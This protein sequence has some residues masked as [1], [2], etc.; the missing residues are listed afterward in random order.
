MPNSTTKADPV[1]ARRPA[2][3]VGEIGGARREA[4]DWIAGQLRWERTLEAV[5]ARSVRR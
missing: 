1:K 2:P 4:L 5:R 3:R